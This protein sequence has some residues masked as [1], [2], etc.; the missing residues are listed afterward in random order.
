MI[1]LQKQRCIALIIVVKILSKAI[2]DLINGGRKLCVHKKPMS[3]IVFFFMFQIINVTTTATGYGLALTCDTLV[4]Q[5]SAPT[6]DRMLCVMVRL[7]IM[8][9]FLALNP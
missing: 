5:V 6:K 7:H 4:S 8:V 2:I 3:L 1:S 9:Q